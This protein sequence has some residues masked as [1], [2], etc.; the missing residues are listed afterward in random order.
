[1]NWFFL[2]VGLISTLIPTISFAM[3]KA[4]ERELIL[5]VTGNIHF[6]TSADEQPKIVG[7]NVTHIT[8]V[9]LSPQQDGD[10]FHDKD[11]KLVDFRLH[12]YHE[13]K[14]H[15]AD[16]TTFNL[17][18]TLTN[19]DLI[20]LTTSDAYFP[21]LLTIKKLPRTAQTTSLKIA[22]DQNVVL[23]LSG[24]RPTAVMSLFIG[25]VPPQTPRKE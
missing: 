22:S 1:M 2:T 16:E 23:E 12:K 10:L 4:E 25:Y 14:K 5:F 17:L 21:M 20:T 11:R 6:S 9:L 24:K 3:E 18:A 8:A 15:W 19:V 13:Q 7:N